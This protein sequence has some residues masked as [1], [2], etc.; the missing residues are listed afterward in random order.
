MVKPMSKAKIIESMKTERKRLYGYFPK[1]TPEEIE[2]PGVVG[3][4]SVKD[5]LAHLTAWE[6]LFLGWY[7]DE[8]QGKEVELPAPGFTWAQM[9]ELNQ[10]IFEEHHGKSFEMIKE[11][12]ADS[13]E[14]ILKT[15]E[16]MDEE[17]LN[18]PGYYPWTGKYALSYLL[19][20]CTDIHYKWTWQLVSKWMR[21][22]PNHRPKKEEII[23]QILVERRRLENNLAKLTPKQLVE[24][25]VVGEWSVKDILAH[26]TAWEK[27]FLGWYD[28]GK[29]GEVPETPAPGY[30]WSNYYLL[31]DKIYKNNK[32]RPLEDVQK[33]FEE[34]YQY[35]LERVKGIPE[36]E[37][38]EMKLYAWMEDRVHI[39]RYIR[40]NTGNHYRW[41][42]SQI[43]KWLREKGK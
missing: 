12:G 37:W 25:G 29:R 40:A 14:K 18:E 34:H 42:K 36:E 20:E 24:P 38:F 17:V 35:T 7:E 30:T 13:F 27:L 5:L 2:E 4:W 3:E 9:D 23:E 32:D 1:F 26:L 19:R 22:H 11:E 43:L 41:A 28:A 6:Q 21:N 33:E 15:V 16:G 8:M 31:N 10:Q 39:A